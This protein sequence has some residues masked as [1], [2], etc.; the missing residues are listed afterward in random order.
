MGALWIVIFATIISVMLIIRFVFGVVHRLRFADRLADQFT[1]IVSEISDDEAYPREIV[2]FLFEMGKHVD[3]FVFAAKLGYRFARKLPTPTVSS[4]QIRGFVSA[5]DRLDEERR[6]R[7][8]EAMALF[9]SSLSYRDPLFGTYIREAVLGRSRQK[10]VKNV[11]VALAEDNNLAH[12][13][14]A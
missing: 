7:F 14:H 2:N 12:L 1:E 9:L 10:T 11:S 13:V 5:I 8:V 4:A 6:A 3:S